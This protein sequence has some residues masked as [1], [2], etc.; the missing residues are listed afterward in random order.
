M[1]RPD[2]LHWD[3][4]LPMEWSMERLL[5]LE[6]AAAVGLGAGADDLADPELDAA[7]AE[8]EAFGSDLARL[9]VPP[10]DLEARTAAVVTDGLLARS[11]LSAAVDLLGTGWRVFR[12]WAPRADEG[13][14]AAP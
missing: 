2:D 4:E 10:S 1:S 5:E 9:L 11:T 12:L 13:E 8:T 14:E 7:L 3:E 6:H